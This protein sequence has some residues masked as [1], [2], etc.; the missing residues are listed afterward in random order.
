MPVADDDVGV[1]PYDAL[2]DAAD[3]DTTDVVVVVDCGNQ[4]F[5]GFLVV[6]FGA[7]DMAQ[8]RFKSGIRFSPSAPSVRVLVPFLPLQ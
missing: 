8:N 4:Q 2:F 1:C 3:T 6:A 5:C 7:G